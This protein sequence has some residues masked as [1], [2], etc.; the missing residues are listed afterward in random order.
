MWPPSI[1]FA[2]RRGR[3]DSLSMSIA[4]VPAVGKGIAEKNMSYSAGNHYAMASDATRCDAFAASIAAAA[5]GKRVLDV[6]SGPFLLLGRLAVRELE[7]ALSRAS[8]TRKSRSTSRPSCCGARTTCAAAWQREAVEARGRPWCPTRRRRHT[9]RRR[10]RRLAGR[11]TC[12][13]TTSA[14]STLP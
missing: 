3:L 10:R 4:V 8:S 13:S 11:P 1:V 9:C 12:R 2:P 5:A 6:G 14:T 7:R